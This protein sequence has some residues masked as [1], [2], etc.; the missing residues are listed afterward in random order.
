VSMLNL[1]STRFSTILTTQK[2]YIVESSSNSSA[3]IVSRNF[4]WI[5]EIAAKINKQRENTPNFRPIS[6][7]TSFYQAGV[8]IWDPDTNTMDGL[9]NLEVALEVAQRAN[10]IYPGTVNALVFDKFAGWDWELEYSNL[11]KTFEA[12]WASKAASNGIR[13]GTI[14]AL[15]FCEN[16][17]PLVFDHM[18]EWLALYIIDLGLPSLSQVHQYSDSLMRLKLTAASKC[19]LKYK[20]VYPDLEVMVKVNCSEVAREKA[21]LVEDMALCVSM[22]NEWGSENQV[23]IIFSQAFDVPNA[24]AGG[25]ISGDPIGGWWKLRKLSEVNITEDTFV[26]KIKGKRF[27][28]SQIF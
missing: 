8:K 11:R 20:Q 15:D 4:T 21:T 16:W 12:G 14:I 24:F 18:Q 23:E 22:V 19:R 25:Y 9:L 6:V 7:I 13:V 10:E 17:S 2:A 1:I 28:D 26:E 5:P 27:I 3:D